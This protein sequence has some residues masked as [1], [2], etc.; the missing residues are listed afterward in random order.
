MQDHVDAEHL[1][2]DI[3]CAI[4]I[5]TSGPNPSEH[6][7]LEIC[8]LPLNSEIKYSKRYAPLILQ[9][10]PR[11]PEAADE[12]WMSRKVREKI[13]F[14]INKGMSYYQTATFFD[15]WFEKLER[16]FNKKIQPL[17][18]DFS[19]TTPFLI[20][21]LGFETY[22]QCFDFRTRSLL[23][24]ALAANDRADMKSQ[25]YPIQKMTMNY[26]EDTYKIDRQASNRRD[27]LDNALT[28]AKLYKHMLGLML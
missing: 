20:D 14:Y 21:L 13:P 23:T 1:N 8:I 7:V 9:V 27:P 11:F 19:K 28:Y 10:K 26:L 3:L 12:R 15:S 16:R 17:A 5:I 24:L 6:D 22:T 4:D 25:P 18:Y 2:N